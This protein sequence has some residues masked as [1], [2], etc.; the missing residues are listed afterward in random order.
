MSVNQKLRTDKLNISDALSVS[1][2]NK[3][4]SETL[5]KILTYLLLSIV[6]ATMILPLLWMLS[7][8]LKEA[9]AVF[10]FP[11]Q[12]IPK[13]LLWENYANAWKSMP[14][15]RFYLNSVFVAVMVTAGQVITSSMAAYAFSRL[16]F[17]GRDNLFLGYLATMMIPGSVTMIPVFILIKQMGLIDTY[18]ALILPGFFSAFGTF[19]LRQ[20]FMGLPRELEEAA[21][22][23]GCSLFGIFWKIILPLSKPALATL[24]TLTFMG[25][26]GNFMWPL[27]VTNSLEMKTLPIGLQSFQGQYSTDWTLLM[28]ASI[29]VLLPVIVV[30]LV[31][32]RFF[33]EGIQL[34]AVKG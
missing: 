10:A 16:N 27:I 15:G 1:K 3:R 21:K 28:A 6:G 33:V 17:P 13:P 34:G 23:D 18:T 31:N 4:V 24:T 29:I 30:F 5:V 20:F 22:I 14:F 8:S 2:N 32:Q 11:P 7:T 9:G 19:M 26:W 25:S 12:W